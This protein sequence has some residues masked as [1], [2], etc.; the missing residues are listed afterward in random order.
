MTKET[1]TFNKGVVEVTIIDNIIY[2]KPLKLFN[3][4]IAI[5]MTKYL[6]KII[7]NI[8]GN[9]VRIWDSSGLPSGFFLMTREGVGQIV[10]WSKGIEKKR[11]HSTDYFIANH[12]LAFGMSR[13]YQLQANDTM[14]VSVLRSFDELPDEIKTKLTISLRLY[15]NKEK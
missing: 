5:E 12:P 14:G 2:M 10:S 9:L 15:V 3:D 6:D 7:D 11:S 4:D 1:L 8:P 13:M